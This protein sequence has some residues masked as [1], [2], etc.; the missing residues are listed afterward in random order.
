MERIQIIQKLSN[1]SYLKN[2]TLHFVPIGVSLLSPGISAMKHEHKLIH[3]VVSSLDRASSFLIFQQTV[4]CM[5]MASRID[6]ATMVIEIECDIFS[7]NL[8]K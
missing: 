4:C 7:L 2:S 8:T 5:N 1:I 6:G 3:F